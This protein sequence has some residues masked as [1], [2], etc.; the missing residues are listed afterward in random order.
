ML[1]CVAILG[2]LHPAKFRSLHSL[3]QHGLVESDLIPER[4]CELEPELEH[5]PEPELELALSWGGRSNGQILLASAG[6][7]VTPFLDGVKTSLS[8]SSWNR[9]SS[10]MICGTLGCWNSLGIRHVR[11]GM[12]NIMLLS[13][14]GWLEFALFVAWPFILNVFG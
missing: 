7:G 6:P 2:R 1:E 11:R 3:P 12:L 14:M 8:A 10:R 4:C 9:F 5:E 13:G